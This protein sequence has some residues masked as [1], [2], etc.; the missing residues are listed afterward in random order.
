[1]FL[2]PP[3]LPDSGFGGALHSYVVS[4]APHPSNDVITEV[5]LVASWPVVGR[6]HCMRQ[7]ELV[8]TASSP[9]DHISWGHIGLV[10]GG[11]PRDLLWHPLALSSG[12]GGALSPVPGGA[13]MNVFALRIK[14]RAGAV[15]WQVVAALPCQEQREF[16][17]LPALTHPMSPNVVWKDLPGA[18]PKHHGHGTGKNCSLLSDALQGR[19]TGLPRSGR[20]QDQSHF[21]GQP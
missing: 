5:L 12:S 19:M 8:L 10:V 3:A 17:H 1:M 13:Q 2:Q 20:A 15:F 7:D 21:L 6:C 18:G 16:P 11:W 14:G 9:G 4:L